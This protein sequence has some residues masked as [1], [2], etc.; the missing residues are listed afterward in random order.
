LYHGRR[1]DTGTRGMNYSL[2]I[3][4][5]FGPFLL[6][7]LI[8]ADYLRKYKTDSF[9]RNLFFSLLGISLIAIF[10]DFVIFLLEG[11]PGEKIRT[12]IIAASTGYFF[13]QI[14]AYYFIFAFI[15][16]LSYKDIDRTWIVLRIILGI[17]VMHVFL[18]ALNIP[19]GF[20]FY[21]S[22]D[23]LYH[24]GSQYFI[25]MI[26]SYLPALFAI[27]EIFVSFK[28][29][30]KY[31][32]ILVFFFLIFAG[33]GS[34]LDILFNTGSLIWPCLTAG[35]LYSYF[36]II[37]S[38]SRIDSLTGLGNRFSFNEFIE[39]LSK[40]AVKE[41]RSVVMID[42]DHFKEIN[43]TL[44]HLEGDN[45]LRDMAAIIKG[46]VRH[47]DFAARYGG[48]EF[49]LAARAEF[50]IQKLMERIQE[51]I[52]NQNKKNYRPYKLAMSYGCDV[53]TTNSGQHIN[54]FLKHID[55]LMYK[56][57]Q[58]KSEGKLAASR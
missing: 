30:K 17:T 35:Y 3:N 32:S 34:T 13:F 19:S 38:D 5:V 2:A 21:V 47:S 11:T 45:A 15:D 50:D 51:S 9:L 26:L 40:L 12:L 18:L 55:D 4:A 41:S 25:R 37:V 33:T 56:E 31:Q 44:G 23:N 49:N 53:Y 48:D 20:Y 14:A 27:I 43:D 36:F 39:K 29:I 6:I 52:D 16:Y 46:S 24:H 57:K 8:F 1:R 7:V 58:F 54:D 28:K 10:C 42:M 22:E